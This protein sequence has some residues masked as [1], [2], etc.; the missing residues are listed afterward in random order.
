[1]ADERDTDRLAGELLNLLKG[2]LTKPAPGTTAK[3]QAQVDDNSMLS[4]IKDFLNQSLPGTKPREQAGSQ[5][6]AQA[7][8]YSQSSAAGSEV[9]VGGWEGLFRR[10]AQERG[11]M[12]ERQE[13]ERGEM[14][15]R[16][17]Q[18]MEAAM[19]GV[20]TGTTVRYGESVAQNIQGVPP[21]RVQATRRRVVGPGGM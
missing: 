21:R 12:H 20:G 1:M 6:T 4:T 15:Q 9:Q 16:H 18:E 10:Q 19:R 8:T 13:R 11:T 3:P 2:S 14:H 17:L 5:S 7:P